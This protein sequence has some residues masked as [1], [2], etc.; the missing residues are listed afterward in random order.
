MSCHTVSIIS[1]HVNIHVQLISWVFGKKYT[2]LFPEGILNSL[3][4][5]GQSPEG[6]KMFKIPSGNKLY[7]PDQKLMILSLLCIPLCLIYFKDLIVQ[8]QWNNHQFL[9]GFSLDLWHHSDVIMIVYLVW[10]NK[11]FSHRSVSCIHNKLS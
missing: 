6:N 2:N 5:E 11:L 8:K 3:F 1:G 10:G 9:K 7:I 4:H